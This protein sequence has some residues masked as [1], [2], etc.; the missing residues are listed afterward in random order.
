MKRWIAIVL[1]FT[2]VLGLAACAGQ[3]AA[4]WEEQYELGARYLS[5]GNYEEAIIAFTAAIEIDPMRAEAYVGRGDAYR[6]SGQL[7]QAESDYRK[8][9]ELDADDWDTAEKLADVLADQ[10]KLE[11]AAGILEELIGQDPAN[12]DYYDDLADIYEALEQPDKV[13]EAL[14]QGVEQTGDEELSDRLEE[15]SKQDGF[16]ADA[17]PSVPDDGV[18]QQVVEISSG[19][20]LTELSYSEG[21]RDLEIHLGDG[22]YEVNSLFFYGAEN[23]SIIGTGRTRLVSTYGTE[24]IISLFQCE[25]VLLYGLVMGHDLE[26]NMGCSTGVVELLSS[27]DISIVGCDI[28]GCGLQ[29]INADYSDF[30]V[31]NCTIRDCS[32]HG[33]LMSASKG[34]FTDCLFSGNCYKTHENPLFR[35]WIEDCEVTLESCTL[36]DNFSQSKYEML[37]DSGWSEEDITESGNGWQ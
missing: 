24:T 33:V 17:L 34:S 37:N 23:V 1:A 36:L 27:S 4:T 19:E 15:L 16:D 7:T 6:Q 28:Y 25:D 30:S 35:A 5:E 32:E 14:E 10:G 22:D 26:P 21:L 12:P 3:K 29:G 9:L 11:E 2:L 13:Q 20:E 8:A 18:R 31:E